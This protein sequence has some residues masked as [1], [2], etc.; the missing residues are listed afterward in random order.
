MGEKKRGRKKKI[1]KGGRRMG[2]KKKGRKK[3]CLNREGFEE[4]QK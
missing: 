2:E 3:K 1:L 4:D